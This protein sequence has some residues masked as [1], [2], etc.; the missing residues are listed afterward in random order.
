MDFGDPMYPGEAMRTHLSTPFLATLAGWGLLLVVLL[1][2]DLREHAAVLCGVWA[3]ATVGMGLVLRRLQ[4]SAGRLA[5]SE[6]RFR[7]IFEASSDA[8]GVSRAGRHL[9][10]NDAYVRMF[11]Y[12]TAQEVLALP[13]AD[14][15]APGA[16]PLI[17]DRA[18]R[19]SRGEQLPDRYETRGLRKDGSEFLME[20]RVSLHSLE[21]VANTAVILRDV[22]ETRQMEGSLARESAVN[23]TMER[24]SKR[25]L[26]ATSIEE[27]SELTLAEARAFTDSQFGCVGHIDPPTGYLVSSTLTRDI[28]DQC[29]VAAKT[30]VFERFTGLWGWVLDHREPLM[31]NQ[32]QQDAR[33]Q[34]VPLGHLPI[35]RFLSVPALHGDT[36]VGQISLANKPGDY[37]EG[38][39][40]AVTR[41]AAVFALGIHRVRAEQALGESRAQLAAMIDSAT[42]AIVSLGEDGKVLVF[43]A[44]AERMFGVPAGQVVGGSFDR[45]VAGALGEATGS[46]RETIGLR[47]SGEEFPLET[48]ISQAEV[49]GRR[50]H[51]AILRDLSE[52][53]RAERQ[54]ADLKAA[55][56]AAAEDWR[57]TFDAME[58]AVLLLDAEG[59]AVRLNRTAGVL[60]G[61]RPRDP[62]GL[63]PEELGPGEPWASTPSLLDE[64]RAGQAKP[65]QVR[66]PFTGRFWEMGATPMAG[67]GF[68]LLARDVTSVVQLQRSMQEA[69]RMAAM[70][71]LTAGVAHEVRNPLFA[72]SANADALGAVLRDRP[73]VADL[74]N[75]VKKEV[76][77]LGNLMS[78]LLEFGKPPAPELREGRF[79]EAVEPAV[80]NGRALAETRGVV[81]EYGKC[82]ERRICMDQRRLGQVFDNLLENAIQHSPSGASV[83]VEWE[84]FLEGGREWVRCRV[85]DA[86]AGFSPQ[87]LRRVFEPFFTKR[88]G[89]T[90]LGLSIAQRIAA[91]HGGRIRAGNGPGGGALMEVELPC[92]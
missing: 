74:T 12:A 36:L 3:L 44:A 85:A 24:L 77:R 79:C 48:S 51:T 18:E 47:S 52:R 67:G 2:F 39:L 5:A 29:R 53:Q 55:L 73:D 33:S 83:R 64:A 87:D 34:G 89:G 6:G 1:G 41:L 86:G 80:R 50:V 9:M 25:L 32:P 72:I 60:L 63:K 54:Q 20:V 22:T 23:A 27:M 26:A 78:D 15:I 62:V 71:A 76:A 91:Q 17:H 37:D 66:D 75:A 16:R 68:V 14:L 61:D 57:R 19:R 88:R 59:R 81:I 49:G 46:T 35:Q 82:P 56:Q 13:I 30:V 8:V 11:G 84:V 40:R 65:R 7:A 70:G 10:V 92:A 90:G 42:D 43:N 21:G 45:F 4:D 69:E 31:T 28:W 58:P 38:D